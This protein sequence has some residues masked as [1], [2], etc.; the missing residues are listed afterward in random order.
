MKYTSYSKLYPP[1]PE[2]AIMPS[3][4]AQFENEFF[5]QV[6]MNGTCS[7]ITV[8]PSGELFFH[9]RHLEP[10]KAWIPNKNKLE[11]F[12]SLKGGWYVFV[13]ELMHSK[14]N[15]MRDVNYIHDVIVANGEHLN[16]KT[17]LQRQDILRDIF[18]NVVDDGAV[19]HLVIDEYTWLAKNYFSNFNKL[20]DNLTKPE[21]EGVVLK[22]KDTKLKLCLN[23]TANS[24]HQLKARKEHNNYSF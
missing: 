9:T 4:I 17:S 16:G 2:N 11:A 23:K 18:P 24:T 14:G 15:G 22:P 3:I 21:F 19:S 20:F 8:S 10:H 12:S 5:A 7:V 13:S 6:K 1:R